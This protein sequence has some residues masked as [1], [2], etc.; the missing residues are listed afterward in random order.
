MDDSES[1]PNNDSRRELK[2]IALLVAVGV[3]LKLASANALVPMI[4]W[5]LD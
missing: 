2:L 4:A 5:E 3:L 1:N